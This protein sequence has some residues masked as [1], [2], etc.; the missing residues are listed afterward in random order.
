[1]PVNSGLLTRAKRPTVGYYKNNELLDTLGAF[2]AFALIHNREGIYI[3][4]EYTFVGSSTPTDITEQ[5]IVAVIK[6]ANK[7]GLCH[8]IADCNI[9]TPM[10]ETKPESITL[11]AYA[12]PKSTK[13]TMVKYDAVLRHTENEAFANYLRSNPEEDLWLFT[14]TGFIHIPYLDIPLSYSP[15]GTERTTGDTTS[16][17]GLKFSVMGK[18]YAGSPELKLAPAS[19]SKTFAE[20]VLTIGT[21]VNGTILGTLGEVTR[22]QR[23]SATS[24]VDIPVSIGGFQAEYRLVDYTT[25]LDYAGTAIAYDSTNNK[26]VVAA[27]APAGTLTIKL[28]AHNPVGVTGEKLFEIKLL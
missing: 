25:G 7:A 5:N 10:A 18:S 19:D 8:F 23:T 28:I 4:G 6:D 3:G 12:G 14:N 21:L 16:A 22:I 24:V 2:W 1:M 27:N 13:I 26:L 20:Y 17:G 15:V 11:A 9:T